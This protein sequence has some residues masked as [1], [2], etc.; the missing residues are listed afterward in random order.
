[1]LV[2]YDPDVFKAGSLRFTCG[3]EPIKSNRSVRFP[4]PVKTASRH[5]N[6]EPKTW[7]FF[8]LQWATKRQI[9]LLHWHSNFG[10]GRD[11]L[12][13][14]EVKATSYAITTGSF[15]LTAKAAGAT[16]YNLPSSSVEVKCWCSSHLTSL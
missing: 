11:F 10:K 5:F 6:G 13:H 3:G 9:D 8:W 7:K 2:T 1:M 16:A 4:R 15:S 14:F 12:K